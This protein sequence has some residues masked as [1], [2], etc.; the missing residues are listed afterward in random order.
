MS[1]TSPLSPPHSPYHSLSLVLV[2][3]ATR[4]AWAMIMFRRGLP[5]RALSRTSVTRDSR[6][7]MGR[8]MRDSRRDLSGKSLNGRRASTRNSLWITAQPRDR[9]RVCNNIEDFT[10]GRRSIRHRPTVC[11]PGALRRAGETGSRDSFAE[12]AANPQSPIVL[13][14]R[15][16][17]CHSCD[18]L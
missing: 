12:D 17:N 1:G 8:N 14:K 9:L 16:E 15:I 6:S 7:R 13:I 11:L 3:D 18:L 4:D 10:C 5:I 2:R